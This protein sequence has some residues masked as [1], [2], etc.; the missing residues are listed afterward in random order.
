MK[1][2]K[3]FWQLMEVSHFHLFTEPTVILILTHLSFA[4]GLVRK[5]R[6]LLTAGAYLGSALEIAGPWLT[7]YV[8][9]WCAYLLLL[10]W[11]LLLACGL[12]LFLISV[13]ALLGKPMAEPTP[14]A[15]P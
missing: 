7:R 11:A 3:E 2:P 6:V 15:R 5:N 12:A 14:E 4:T 8:G 13:V 10:G 9:A 1:F